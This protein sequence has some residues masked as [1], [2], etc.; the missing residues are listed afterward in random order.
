MKY[1][2]WDEKKNSLLK[3]LREVSFEDVQIAIEGGRV[4]DEIDHPN[5]KRYPNQRIL[6]V[7]I[8]N[9][10]YYV[11]YVEDEEKIF[12]KTIFPSRRA[13]KKYLYGGEKK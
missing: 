13:T 9:Y 10:A 8:E 1:F 11:P 12:L 3:E 5:K 4:L 2:D 7:E 6:V